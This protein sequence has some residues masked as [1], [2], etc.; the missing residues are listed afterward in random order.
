MNSDCGQMSKGC[1]L[2]GVSD[3]SEQESLEST[4]TCGLSIVR[5]W[6]VKDFYQSCFSF[7]L[8]QCYLVKFLETT[9]RLKLLGVVFCEFISGG[10]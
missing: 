4:E 5:I 8:I 2:V 6:Y 1:D 9:T 7:L 10:L 3:S